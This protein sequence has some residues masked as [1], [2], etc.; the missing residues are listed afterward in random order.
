MPFRWRDHCLYCWL[1]SLTE[2][3]RYVGVLQQLHSCK[4]NSAAGRVGCYAS[5]WAACCPDTSL[6]VAPTSTTRVMH[7]LRVVRELGMF[8]VGVLG[9]G[10]RAKTMASTVLSTLRVLF[11]GCLC[12]LRAL[13][14]LH[15]CWQ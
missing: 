2:C 5:C 13:H 15:S 14:K 10:R 8:G 12:A 9:K 11:S 3:Q 7:L 1:V 6:G 4:Q